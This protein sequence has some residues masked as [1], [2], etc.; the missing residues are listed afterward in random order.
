[1]SIAIGIGLMVIVVGILVLAAVKPEQIHIQR[2]IHVNSSKGAVFA[3]VNNFRSWPSWAP[4]DKDDPTMARTY[5]GSPSGSGARSDWSSTGR[6]GSGKMTIVQSTPPD[7]VVIEVE[8]DKPFR[9]HNV[10]EFNF[11]AA[12]GGTRVTWSMKG[13]NAYLMKVMSLWIDMDRMMG[14]HF[15]DGLRNLKS[16]AELNSVA[17]CMNDPRPQTSRVF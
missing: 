15:D 2:Q 11:E 14:K 10:N 16:V 3:L 5:H 17:T 9:A 1:M 13:T 8:F 12:D 4:Q 7:K 6:A